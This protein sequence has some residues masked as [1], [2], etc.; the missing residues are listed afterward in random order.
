VMVTLCN[1]Y[2]KKVRVLVI[3]SGLLLELQ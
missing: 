1:Q 2:H 3:L